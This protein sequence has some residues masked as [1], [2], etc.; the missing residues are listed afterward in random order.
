MPYFSSNFST[1]AITTLEQSVSGMKPMRTSFFSGAS[2][3]AAQAAER[4]PGGTMLMSEAPTPS[5]APCL[6]KLRRVA[7]VSMTPS[8][9]FGCSAIVFS[10]GS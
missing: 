6:R 5:A 1:A 4:T 10:V 8:A 3:P 7:P 9:C 2:E